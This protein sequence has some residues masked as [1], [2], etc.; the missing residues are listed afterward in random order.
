[1]T[2]DEAL[3]QNLAEWRP[4]G[5]R[6]TLNLP[7]TGSGWTVALT[8]DRSDALGCLVWE[9]ALRRTTEPAAGE[10]LR[11]WAERI[12]GRVT[13]LLEPLKVVEVDLVRGQAL[14]RSQAPARRGEQLHYY[15]VLLTGV[16]AAVVRRY[17]ASLQ[18]DA[19]R[20][21]VPFTLTH[22]ALAKLAGDLSA[23]R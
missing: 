9:L 7:D 17:R 11:A 21:Q 13:G 12:A 16:R 5:G 8:A 18:G 15:E 22:E 4:G 20:E 1:M 6:Q 23:S 2:L 3:L 19:R 14:L 10:G